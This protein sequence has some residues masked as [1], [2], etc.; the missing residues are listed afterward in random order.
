[1]RDEGATTEVL[2]AGALMDWGGV[3]ADVLVRKHPANGATVPR[4]FGGQDRGR[5]DGSVTI[6]RS[7]LAL[8]ACS[9]RALR[10][11]E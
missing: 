11:V 5:V 1:V 2:R 4:P 6:I 9:T 3:R 8:P 7:I 10:Q